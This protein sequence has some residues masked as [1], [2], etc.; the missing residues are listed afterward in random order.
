M[1]YKHHRREELF[2]NLG[3]RLKDQKLISPDGRMA[4]IKYLKY[5]SYS[6]LCVPSIDI[7][8]IEKDGL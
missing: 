4:N 6:G 3:Y 8:E 1:S 7:E 2:Y 5:G